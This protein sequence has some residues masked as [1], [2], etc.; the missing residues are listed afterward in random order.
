MSLEDYLMLS[1]IK[2]SL[3]TMRLLFIKD[4]ENTIDQVGLLMRILNSTEMVNTT[5][6]SLSY[7]I[8]NQDHM[9]LWLKLLV[10]SRISRDS[11]HCLHHRSLNK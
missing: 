10:T 6:D 3:V 7:T 8:F 1:P 11:M 4:L 2:H 9:L 5:Q